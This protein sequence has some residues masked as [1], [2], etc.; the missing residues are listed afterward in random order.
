MSAPGRP[1]P[2]PFRDEMVRHVAARAPLGF[3]VFLVCLALSTFFEMIRFPERR[4]WMGLFAA[5]FVA[6]AGGAWVGIR[7]RPDWTIPVLVGFVNLIGAGV[8][9]YHAIVGA[10]V[11]MCVWALTAVIA[12]SG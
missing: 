4:M 10:S 11:A 8:N 12:S 3:A 6:L 5:A 2:D 9:V 7:R 1:A